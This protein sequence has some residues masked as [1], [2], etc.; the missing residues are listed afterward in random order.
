M[1]RGIA[2]GWLVFAVALT[3]CSDESSEGPCPRGQELQEG[4]FSSEQQM[5][6]FRGCAGTVDGMQEGLWTWWYENGQKAQ[7]AVFKY[8]KEEGP[9]TWWYQSGQKGVEG[10]YKN[11]KEEG[12]WTW[13]H[14]NGQKAMEGAF[15]NG[16]EDGLWILWHENGQKEQ[17]GAYRV[18]KEEG[19]WTA[20]YEDGKK[21][22]EGAYVNGKREGVWTFWDEDGQK[23]EVVYKG[24]NAEG[25]GKV[26][27]CGDAICSVGELCNRAKS[28]HRCQ[29]TTSPDSCSLADPGLYCSWKRLACESWDSVDTCLE[30]CDSVYG[31]PEYKPH[32]EI[33]GIQLSA[34]DCGRICAAGELEASIVQCLMKDPCSQSRRAACLVP[35]N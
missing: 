26:E 20:W 16:L 5:M 6:R 29:C 33:G 32:L 22:L 18:G 15:K 19:V 23:E 31:C 12:T 9:W 7:E 10:A 11:G 8:G 28:P 35:L 14:A 30:M 1:L 17:E 3:S 13:W 27:L 24:G 21:R 34:A 2:R 4:S 25:D